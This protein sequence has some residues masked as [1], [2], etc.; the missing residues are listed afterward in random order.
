VS[1]GQIDVHSALTALAAQGIT[2]VFCEGGGALAAALLKAKLVDRLELFQAGK[3]IG[4]D[5]LSAVAGT[6]TR[7]LS[8]AATFSC[9]S[10]QRI[11]ADVWTS[12]DA[13]H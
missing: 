8:E 6:H 10:E 9:V 3:I 12:W 7:A 1:D 5:G 4:G 2:R 13:A 11:G